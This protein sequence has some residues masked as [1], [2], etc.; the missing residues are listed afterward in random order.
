MFA[1]CVQMWLQR[2]MSEKGADIFRS[3]GIIRIRGSNVK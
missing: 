1:V 3:K 2:L